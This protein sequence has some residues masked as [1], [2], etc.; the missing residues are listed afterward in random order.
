MRIAVPVL[1]VFFVPGGVI[2]QDTLTV[3]ADGPPVWGGAPELVEEIRIGV[4]EGD[5]N[6]SFGHVTGVAVEDDGTIWVADSQN[7]E[8][9]R[10]SSDGEFLSL[11]A[12]RGEGPGE[13]GGVSG[14]KLLPDGRIA[15]FDAHLGRITFFR[16]GGSFDGSVTRSDRKVVVGGPPEVFQVDRAG[17]FYLF[18]MRLRPREDPGPA[19]ALWLKLDSQGQVVDSLAIPPTG[20]ATIGGRR[21]PFGEMGSFTPRTM[22]VL[23]PEGYVVMGSN[24]DYALYRPLSDGRTLR[25]ER[26]WEPIPVKR[27]ER[28]QYR[29]RAETYAERWDPAYG[30]GSDIPSVKPPFWAM[31]VDEEGRLWVARHAEGVFVPESPEEQAQR[32]QFGNP[33]AE[34]WE[35]LVVDVIEPRGRYL[36][37]LHFPGYGTNV[38][39]ARGLEVWTIELGEFD[40]QYVVRYRVRPSSPPGD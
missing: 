18:S 16:P 33:P 22:S 23:S 38:A 19:R 30:F 32:E 7:A 21:Y 2:A 28:A 34:W 8:V 37:T 1:T 3:R 13:L 20:R 36:G 40:E 14:I 31:R 35:P 27:D 15:V 4:L 10:F 26:T 29:V 9:R 6:L 11:V 12:S 5:I 24:D 17:A 25:I 39:A